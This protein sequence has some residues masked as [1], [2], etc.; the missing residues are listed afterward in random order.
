M[1]TL[2]TRAPILGAAGVA[3]TVQGPAL[4]VGVEGSRI[5]DPA[6][7]SGALAAAGAS[8]AQVSTALAAA[9]AHPTYFEPVFTLPQST[10][11]RLVRRAATCIGS[12]APSFSRPTRVSGHARPRCPPGG[13]SGPDQCRA[14][15]PARPGL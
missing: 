3:L 11:A 10:F 9:A 4:I 2:A 8:A 12:R 15:D 14:T 5:K 1:R 7:V 6:A 13:I